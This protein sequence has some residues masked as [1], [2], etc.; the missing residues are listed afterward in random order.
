MATI[1]FIG[2]WAKQWQQKFKIPK[3]YILI[4]PKD[5]YL[6][7]LLNKFNILYNFQEKKKELRELDINIEY[8]YKKRTIDQNNL[9]WA[10]Y[11]IESN[12][13]NAGM[14]GDIKQNISTTEL[15]ENDLLTYAPR[16]IIKTSANELSFLKSQYRIEK[17]NQIKDEKGNIKY[18][19]ITA[20][21]STS[22]FTT[23]QMA[24][25]I[26]R[27]FN[28]MAFN[29][30]TCTN[31]SEIHDYWIK[32]RQSLS[33][34]KIILH[35]EVLIGDE[36]KSLNPTCEATGIFI[37]NGTGHLCHIQARGMGGDIIG[38]KDYSS[39]WLHLCQE[40][41]IQTQHQKGW[42]HFLKL[43]PHLKYKVETALRREYQ[44]FN[45]G[46]ELYNNTEKIKNIFEGEQI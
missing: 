9:L 43:Y 7:N 20:I 19:E 42:I 1:K 12:E 6:K 22:H 23:I 8:H 30:I 14:S 41:H 36:Y 17:E 16:I 44:N 5:I 18:Y 29:G 2:Y 33:D 37:G 4:K 24:K 21:L 10:L 38:D 45:E 28:R 26:D 39:N 27:I 11:E 40:A 34:E 35:D 25:W 46:K 32:W 3:G 31:P 15:Y 13:M